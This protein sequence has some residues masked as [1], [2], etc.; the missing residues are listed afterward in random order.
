M[1]KP[2]KLIRSMSITREKLMKTMNYLPRLAFGISLMSSAAVGAADFNGSAP[3]TCT[4][5]AAYSCEPGKACSKVKPES[6]P[7]RVVTIDAREK[8]VRAPY[9]TELLPIANSAL[10]GEQLQLQGTAEK[11]AWSAIVQRR[12]G[13]VTITIADRLGAYVIFGDCQITAAD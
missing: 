3:L 7:P 12:T 11:F 4:P 13:K 8:T 2:H 10:N 9:R 1:S 5:T 6:D